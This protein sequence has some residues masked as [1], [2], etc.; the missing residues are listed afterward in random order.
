MKTPDFLPVD[1]SAETKDGNTEMQDVFAKDGE[2]DVYLNS[3]DA[4][5]LEF[6]SNYSHIEDGSSATKI[7]YSIYR[8]NN[9]VYE[10]YT[11]NA[12]NVSIKMAHEPTVG[13]VPTYTEYTEFTDGKVEFSLWHY[14]NGVYEQTF[15]KNGV[16][17]TAKVEITDGQITSI[18]VT[19]ETAPNDAATLKSLSNSVIQAVINANGVAGV[20]AELNAEQ[21]LVFNAISDILTD[22][23]VL[24]CYT[25]GGAGS[26]KLILTILG[27]TGAYDVGLDA[28]PTGNYMIRGKVLINGIEVADDYFIFRVGRESRYSLIREF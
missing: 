26:N 17:F 24:V 19:S 20:Y 9:G 11:D 12:G 3:D 14:N 2:Y 21:T 15:T 1:A 25:T 16:E 18:D 4:R 27:D 10:L 28:L 5:V 22:E 13:D 7:E 6:T 8:K 23:N